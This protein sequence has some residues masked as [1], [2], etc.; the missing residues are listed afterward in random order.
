MLTV[1]NVCAWCDHELLE[2][3]EPGKKHEIGCTTAMVSH[4]C[5]N[6]CRRKVDA[7]VKAVRVSRRLERAVKVH[8]ILAAAGLEG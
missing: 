8:L 7:K 5:C 1:I 2:N 3:N 4:G 6:Q